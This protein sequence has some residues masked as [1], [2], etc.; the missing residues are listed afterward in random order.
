MGKSWDNSRRANVPRSSEVLG[1]RLRARLQ[2]ASPAEAM[3][4]W[5]G[6][7][8]YPPSIF[9]GSLEVK[10]PTIWRDEKQSREEA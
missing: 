9:E 4:S 3:H 10:L 2:R 1:Q 7:I 6:T 8:H 5:K